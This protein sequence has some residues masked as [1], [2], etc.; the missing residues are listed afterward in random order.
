MTLT[1]EQVDRAAEAAFRVMYSESTGKAGW[2]KWY[3]EQGP[4]NGLAE[5]VKTK[6]REIAKAAIN[7]ALPDSN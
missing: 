3:V 7:A 2:D 6:W 5:N 1:D 4:P